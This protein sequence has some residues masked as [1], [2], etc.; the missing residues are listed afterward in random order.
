MVQASLVT[1]KK[2]VM[3]SQIQKKIKIKRRMKLLSSWT[4]IW[5]A[6]DNNFLLQ[7]FLNSKCIKQRI[8]WKITFIKNA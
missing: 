8:K 1:K 4:K 2:K 6:K 7:D 3:A 5:K